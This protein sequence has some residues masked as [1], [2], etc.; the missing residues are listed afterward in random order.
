[1]GK[2]CMKTLAAD[3]FGTD[4]RVPDGIGY[5]LERCILL[6]V[7]TQHGRSLCGYRFR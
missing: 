1:M 7:L 4:S 2:E 3:D 5:K 6:E